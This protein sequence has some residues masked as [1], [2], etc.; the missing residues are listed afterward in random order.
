VIMGKNIVQL[1]RPQ[2][3]IWR[4]RIAG[5]IPEAKN[6][7]SKYV[8]LIAFLPQQWLHERASMLRY[9]YTACLVALLSKITFP[10]TSKPPK[11]SST[12]VTVTFCELLVL[13]MRAENPSHSNLPYFITAISGERY[14]LLLSLR[15]FYISDASSLL[16][17]NIFLGYLFSDTMNVLLGFWTYPSSVIPHKIYG[18]G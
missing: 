3:T 8:I 18:F 10:S 4:T 16:G 17:T 7:H 14:T 11:W 2:M 15:H 12:S 13:F 9:T 6:I 5:W 1:N